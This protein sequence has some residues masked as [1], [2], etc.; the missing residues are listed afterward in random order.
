MAAMRGKRGLKP[1]QENNFAIV[2]QDRVLET[3]NK[4]TGRLLP[5]HARALQRRASWWAAS[6]SWPS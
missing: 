3:F 2:T 4:M 6:A 5:G 1:A